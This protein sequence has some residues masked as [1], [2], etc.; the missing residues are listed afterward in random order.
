MLRD[1]WVDSIR[2]TS[3]FNEIVQR[4]E[5]KSREAEDELRRLGGDKVLL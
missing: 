1:P 4:A 5:A 3:A 2:G